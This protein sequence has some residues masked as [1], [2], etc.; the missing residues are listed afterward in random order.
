MNEADIN[1]YLSNP[2]TTT[3][4]GF[5]FRINYSH[6]KSTVS[7]EIQPEEILKINSQ[8]NPIYFNLLVTFS[9]A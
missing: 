5:L 6:L 1:N 9:Q 2:N 7:G 3:L 8:Y 4:N